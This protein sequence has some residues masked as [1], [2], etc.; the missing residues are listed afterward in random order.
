MPTRRRPL[1]IEGGDEITDEGII[2]RDWMS[3]PQAAELLGL[4]RVGFVK[5]IDQPGSGWVKARRG[6][7]RYVL[8]SQVEVA[9]RE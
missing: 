3:V 1:V 5:Q 2:T 9:V 7:R 6:R 8:R 4:T